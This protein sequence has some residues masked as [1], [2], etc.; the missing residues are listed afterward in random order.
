MKLN[1][2]RCYRMKVRKEVH[3]IKCMEVKW[4]KMDQNA[5]EANESEPH[6]R[7]ALLDQT[8]TAHSRRLNQVAG[9]RTGRV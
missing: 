9:R 7:Q 6:S 1:E 3:G 5:M 4:I 8:A 2:V